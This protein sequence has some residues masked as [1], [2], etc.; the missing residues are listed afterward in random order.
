MG[1]ASAQPDAADMPWGYL[2]FSD[3]KQIALTGNS[4][5]VGR[6]SQD[7]ESGGPEINLAG[8]PDAN[9][10]SRNHAVITYANDSCTLTDQNSANATRING[11]SLEPNIA[12]PFADGDTLSFGKIT[13]TFRKR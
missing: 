4:I 5:T 12:T 9:T 2:S 13:C 11:Q 8:L 6:S 10:V 3:E 1:N 7:K